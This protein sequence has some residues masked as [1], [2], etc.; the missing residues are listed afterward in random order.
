ML[1]ADLLCTVCSDEVDIVEITRARDLDAAM[2][3][4]DGAAA[5]ARQSAAAAKATSA[6]AAAAQLAPPAVSR[7]QPAARA[8]VPKSPNPLGNLAGSF[9]V[10]NSTHST[11]TTHSYLYC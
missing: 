2:L 11:H 5:H 3:N 4:G 10:R 7:R 6:A 9:M 8:I 1:Q